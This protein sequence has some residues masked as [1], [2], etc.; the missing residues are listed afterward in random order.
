MHHCE[1]CNKWMRGQEAHVAWHESGVGH[2]AK[3]KEQDA[4]TKAKHILLKSK[5]LAEERERYVPLPKE[6]DNTTDI[7]T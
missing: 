2:L 5:K 1:I 6:S 3:M 7:P 4:Q